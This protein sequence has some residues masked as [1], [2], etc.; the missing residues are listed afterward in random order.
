[1]LQQVMPVFSTFSGHYKILLPLPRYLYDSCCDEVD[2]I[3]NVLDLGH[4]DA[5]LADL[6]ATYKLWRG[7]LFKERAKCAKVCNM[8]P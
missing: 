4:V 5:Q 3:P 6:D 1:M 2:H 8:G 7:M